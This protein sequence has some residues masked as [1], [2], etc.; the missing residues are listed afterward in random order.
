[1]K[2]TAMFLAMPLVLGSGAVMAADSTTTTESSST[3][4][5]M[6]ASTESKTTIEKHE[7]LFS[8]KTIEKNKS[9]TQNADGTV[10]MEKSKKVT[11]GD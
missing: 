4:S 1:M 9:T 10:S 5:G 8:D 2:L 11:K 3:D 6:P 7:G